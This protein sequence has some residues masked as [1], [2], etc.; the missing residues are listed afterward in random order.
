M[1]ARWLPQSFDDQE[2]TAAAASWS[3]VVAAPTRSA[4][5]IHAT[6]A[7]DLPDADSF[8]RL[9]SN[10]SNS[11]SATPARTIYGFDMKLAQ[12]QD[13]EMEASALLT[14]PAAHAVGDALGGGPDMPAAVETNSKLSQKLQAAVPDSFQQHHPLGAMK[15]AA[16]HPGTN[17]AAM[18]AAVHS[19]LRAT[20][21]RTSAT[22]VS[23][24]VHAAGK[25]SAVAAGPG[26]SVSTGLTGNVYV[27]KLKA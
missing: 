23:Q 15:L 16:G 6:K 20:R 21:H 12:P 9:S 4:L 8:Q 22:S 26:I 11:S 14:A 24:Q 13:A 5:E 17:I 18:T 1:L 27:V 2:V 10:A 7:A 25:L 19:K 3:A